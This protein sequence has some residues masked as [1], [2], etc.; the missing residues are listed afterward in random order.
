MKYVKIITLL[1]SLA[2]F[3]FGCNDNTKASKQE[4][5]KPLEVLDATTPLNKINPN[6][7]GLEPAQNSGGV[8]H[9]TCNKGCPRG[10]GSAVN[11]DNCGGVLA[12]NTT[13]HAK[14][15]STP[16][17]SA[18]YANP[19]AS[20]PTATPEPSQNKAGVWHYTCEKGCVGGSGGSGA[21]ST[22]GGPLAH[23]TAYH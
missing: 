15:N 22:C 21:C 8:W 10:A 1:F 18:P 20:T 5:S 4:T 16:T 19:P 12:H 9:Y 3:S 6:L 14:A 17:S 23:N 7:A 2:I 11:C 13:Y